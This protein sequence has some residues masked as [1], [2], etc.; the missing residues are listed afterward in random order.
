MGRFVYEEFFSSFLSKGI[1]KGHV[2]SF[3]THFERFKGL[4]V[5]FLIRYTLYQTQKIV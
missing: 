4:W 1:I 5:H 2:F 3:F